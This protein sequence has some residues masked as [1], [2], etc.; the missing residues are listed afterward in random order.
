MYQ[1]HFKGGKRPYL[2]LTVSP[3]LYTT[4]CPLTTKPLNTFLARKAKKTMWRSKNKMKILLLLHPPHRLTMMEGVGATAVG[5]VG[6]GGGVPAIAIGEP[7]VEDVM[8]DEVE[9]VEGEEEEAA[10][11]GV[12]TS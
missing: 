8:G 4:E 11:A 12:K 5:E 1:N 7:I 10:A 6:G 3:V 2:H 9:A